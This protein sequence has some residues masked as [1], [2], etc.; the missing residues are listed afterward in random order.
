MSSKRHRRY[1]AGATAACLVLAGCGGVGGG[2][3]EETA[4]GGVVLTTMGFGLGDEVA[5][6]RADLANA[7]IAPSTVQVG[8]SSFDAQ[9]FLSA[10]ASDTPPDMVFMDRQLI[11]TYASRGTLMPLTDCIE[12]Q[13]VDLSQYR[14]A[15][16]SEV[17]LD[18]QVY[19]LPEFFNNRVVLM[20]D[21]ALQS[22]GLEPAALST[23]DWDALA[24]ATTQLATTDPNG[25]LT[26]I[27]FDPKIP[28][29]FP[30]WAKAN[31]VDMISADGRT[32]NLDDPKLAEVLEYTVGLIDAQG[33]WGRFKAFRE[34]FDFFGE[35]NPFSAD[36]MA[37]FPMEDWYLNQLASN[38]PE[39]PLVVSPFHDR[40][41]NAVDYV[42]GAAWAI[43][44]GSAHPEQACTWIKTMNDAPSWVAA[45]KARAEQRAADGE[46][47]TGLY[48]A[49]RAADEQIF[50]EL[51]QLDDMPVY[52][53]AVSAVLEAQESA[54]SL[55]ASPAGAEFRTA[56]Q[57]AVNRVLEGRQDAATALAQAQQEAQ[58]ALDAA[59]RG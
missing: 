52:D 36:Q 39:V 41:G 33:G 20:N 53:A 6:V 1:A 9:Q 23:A 40:Q 30:M 54:F 24:Q 27:G 14:E 47:F 7:A 51:V 57:A 12:N 11:G 22:A 8:G 4:G 38:T 59:P 31:G 2:G 50:D 43:P 42:T 58:Q 46:A 48:T 34:S 29:F 26:R 10:V 3:E 45:A 18:G 56:W 19:G 13:A 55:P 37:A 28:E 49:N 15:A 17:T 25:D 32:A 21:A 35:Q 5:Q 44:T 16:L